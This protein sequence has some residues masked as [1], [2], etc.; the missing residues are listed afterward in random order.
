[1][2]LSFLYRL[3]RRVLEGVRVHQTDTLSMSKDEEILVLRHQ[4]AVLRRQ[5]A[6]PRFT[7]ADRALVAL[8]AGVVPKDRWSAFLVTPETILAWHRA[9]VRRRWTYPHRRP[10]RPPLTDE[11]VK[12][13]CRL[14]RENP[15]WGYLRILRSARRVTPSA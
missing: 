9:L 6:R 8:L 13:I 7:W 1:M 2:W 15:R 11:T 10:G 4:L 14:A 12:L 5:V 3:A